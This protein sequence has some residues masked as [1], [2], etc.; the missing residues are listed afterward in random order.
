M[1]PV[2]TAAG[3]LGAGVSPALDAREPDHWK[4][5]GYSP[6]DRE[7]GR[8]NGAVRT[9]GTPVLR[10]LP[11]AS[12]WLRACLKSGTGILPVPLPAAELSNRLPGSRCYIIRAPIGLMPRAQGAAALHKALDTT[13]DRWRLHKS[14]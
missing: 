10:W 14:H 13:K 6:R 9:G 12:A 8:A 4:V 5:G 2:R 1:K 3:Q 11:T 7:P